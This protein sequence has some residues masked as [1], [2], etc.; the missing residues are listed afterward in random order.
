MLTFVQGVND[1]LVFGWL[2]VLLLVGICVVIFGS[3]IFMTQDTARSMTATSFIAFGL[4][5]LLAALNLI[6]NIALFITLIVAGVTL[7]LTWPKG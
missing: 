6:P 3:F 7:A 5:I 4:A 1:V 2:G